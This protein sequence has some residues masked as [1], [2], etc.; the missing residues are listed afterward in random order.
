MNK[1]KKLIATL[2]A[3]TLLGHYVAPTIVVVADE[4]ETA[5]TGDVIIFSNDLTLLKLKEDSE[6]Q[7]VIEETDKSTGTIKLLTLNKINQ[8]ITIT[9][10]EDTVTYSQKDLETIGYSELGH[11]SRFRSSN[12]AGFGS[13]GYNYSGGNHYLKIT[14]SGVIHEKNVRRSSSNAGYLDAFRDTVNDIKSTEWSIVGSLGITALGALLS[15]G[16]GALSLLTS[17]GSLIATGNRIIELT[18]RAQG[19]FWN[20]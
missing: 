19:Y 6:T 11:G 9:S 18:N 1:I 20:V 13:I 7:K 4:I 16:I 12:F 8:S 10:E 2:T 5:Q 15:G 3:C 17:S 14:N